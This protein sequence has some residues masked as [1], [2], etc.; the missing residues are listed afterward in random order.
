[1]V[2]VCHCA[3]VVVCN[4]FGHEFGVCLAEVVGFQLVPEGTH[5]LI[6]EVRV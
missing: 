3:V 6:I 5:I 2:V 1:M 4:I